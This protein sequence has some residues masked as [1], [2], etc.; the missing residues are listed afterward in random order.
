MLS[1]L[2]QAAV[3]QEGNAVEQVVVTSTRITAGGFDAPT[4]T[5]VVGA[6]Q[7]QNAAEESVFTVINQIPEMAGSAQTSTGTTSSSAGTDGRSTL[8]LRNLGT[9]RTLVLIDGQRVV[10]VDTTGGTDIAQFPQA[11]IQRVDVVTGGASASWGS[12]AVAGVIN[13]VTDKNFSGFKGSIGG[14]QTT[15]GDGQNGEV[16]LA[17]GS[18]FAGGRGHIEV[19]GEFTTDGGVGS[20]GPG[21]PSARPWYKGWKL[22][23]RPI[24][25]TTTGLPQYIASPYVADSQMSPGGLITGQGT[26]L[27][28]SVVGIA[29]G[30]GGQPF[31]MQFGSVRLDPWMIGGDQRSDEGWGP[32]SESKLTRGNFYARVSYNLTPTTNIWA[33][34]S[35]GSVYTSNVAFYTD[36]KPANLTIQCDNPYLQAAIATACGGAGHSF[37][38]GTMNAD[39]PNIQVQNLR[40]MRRYVM[41]VDGAFSLFGTDWTYE[42]FL[43]HGTNDITNNN[44]N[45]TLTPRYN[46]AIDAIRDPASGVIECRNPNAR[47]EGCLPLDVIGTGVADPSAL[48]WVMYPGRT[49]EYSYLRQETGSLTFNGSPLSDWAGPIS[50][51]TGLEYREEAFKQ[52]ANPCQSNACGDPLLATAGN[53]YFS[54]N[55]H[56]SRGAYH[57][58]E[59]FLET[60]VPLLKD[61]EWGVADLDLAGR[62]TGYSEAG[63]I[64]TWKVGLTYS[65]GFLPGVKFRTLQSRD[66]RAPN[67]NDLYAAPSTP[68]GGVVDKFPTLNGVTNPKYLSTIIVHEATLANLGLAPEKSLTTELGVVYQPDWLPGFSTSLDYYRIGMKGGIGTISAQQEEDLCAAGNTLLCSFIDRDSSNVLLDVNVEKINLSSIV[69]DGFDFEAS[70]AAEL[71]DWIDGLPGEISFRSLGTHVSKFITNSGVPGQAFTESAGANSGS[72]AEYTWNNYQNYSLDRL[73]IT[74]AERWFSDGVNN[75]SFI[76]CSTNCPISTLNNPTI[77][78]NKMDGAFYVDIGLTY[79]ISKG[80]GL[81]ATAFFKVDNVANVDPVPNPQYGSLPISNGTNPSLYDTIGRNYRIGIRF[82]D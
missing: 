82:S 2:A 65:P 79:D 60:V 55:F 68:T 3:A 42:G 43:N 31:P 56:P 13:F 10:G 29:F 27:T 38:F 80:D 19:S 16:S 50:V 48:T 15:Y 70:Y 7:I 71:S 67:L 54:G 18:D 62:A 45:Q 4:P 25:Q 46:A 14:G 73:G 1:M 41:G 52:F 36:Y 40:T 5:T 37:Q 8:S 51:A 32:D 49:W 77:N 63:Y 44:W 6:A 72:I 74:L 78:N 24:G 20:P 23:Q 26:S 33:T 35:Y 9:N 47:A 81:Q 30:P 57:V 64:S 59:A 69:T 61:D 12:D 34:A 28:P 76:Q 21:S 22:L 39:L 66:V 58:S 11:L 17:G 53:N 75:R